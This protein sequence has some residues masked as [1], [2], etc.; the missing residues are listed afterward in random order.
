MSTNLKINESVAIAN[1]A[2]CRRSEGDTS[3][4]FLC[5]ARPW[6]AEYLAAPPKVTFHVNK[7]LYTIY[8]IRAIR[9]DGTTFECRFA[10]LK[11]YHVN[12]NLEE[13]RQFYQPLKK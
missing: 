7:W 5:W 2:H 9:T 11:G 13:I 3:N 1:C 6:I 8:G 4:K 10:P 12:R